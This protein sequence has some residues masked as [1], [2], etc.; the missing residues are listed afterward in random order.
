MPP[1]LLVEISPDESEDHGEAYI[2]ACGESGLART[3]DEVGRRAEQK[4][5]DP[6]VNAGREVEVGR[7]HDQ[8]SEQNRPSG[9]PETRRFH[10]CLTRKHLRQNGNEK[11]EGES[12]YKLAKRLAH[13]DHS[14]AE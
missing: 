12:Q 1:Q 9:I 8:Q 6:G 4:P 11:D 10:I 3:V 13:E 7:D 5:V 14:D 2:G